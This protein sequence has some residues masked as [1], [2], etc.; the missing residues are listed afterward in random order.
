MK[1]LAAIFPALI[2]MGCLARPNLD[3]ISVG[4]TEAQVIKTLGKPKS[5]SGEG[6]TRTL[7][8]ESYQGLAHYDQQFYFV[9]LVDG[10]VQS[11][12]REP[13]NSPDS[14]VTK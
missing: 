14:G 3:Q 9:K 12:G 7:E 13:G 11:F 1:R 6:N 2:L 8:Y 10:K 5:V 4:M